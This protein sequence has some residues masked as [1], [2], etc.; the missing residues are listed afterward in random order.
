MSATTFSG[1]VITTGNMMD[2]LATTGQNT[3]PVAGPD[4]TYHGDSFPDVRYYPIPKDALDNPGV[5]FSFLN[6]PEVQAVNAVPATLGSVGN[7]ASPQGVTSGV[8]MTLATN[9]SLGVTLNVPFQNFATKA[10]VTGKVVLDLG[11]EAPT[12]TASNKTITV[13]DSSIY[14]NGQP[15]I[16]TNVGNAAGTTHLYTYVTGTPT[17][18]TITVADAP[19]ASNSTTSRIASGLPGWANTMGAGPIRPTFYAPYIA[20]GAALLFD[21]TQA[22]ER[23]VSITGSVTALGGN[24]T[25]TGYDIYGQQQTE[26]LTVVSGA[27]TTLSKKCYKVIQAVTPAFTNTANTYS[28]NT[29]DLFGFPFRNDF[30]ENLAVFNAGAFISTS[31]GWTKG[32]KTSPATTTTGDPRGTYSLQSPSNGANR[33]VIYQTLPFLNIVRANPNNPQFLFGVTPV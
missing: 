3:D 22:I 10:L 11:I 6:T 27:S 32:D 15:I 31:T 13:A 33:L 5:V 26:L 25:I 1:P 28:V 14:R 23:G 30:W 8:A 20:G 24:F 19:L 18:T 21:P 17:S 7:V 29:T 12:V 4:I 2:G 9:A 16:V